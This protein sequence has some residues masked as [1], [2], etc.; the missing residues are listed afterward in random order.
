MEPRSGV[1]ETERSRSFIASEAW[2]DASTP[3]MTTNRSASTTS[4]ARAMRMPSRNRR[5][6]ASTVAPVPFPGVLAIYGVLPARCRVRCSVG[7]CGWSV[8]GVS[9]QFPLAENSGAGI[10]PPLRLSDSPATPSCAGPSAVVAELFPVAS[11]PDGAGRSAK[12]PAPMGASTASDGSASAAEEA[13]S[14]A[15]AAC[16]SEGLS[17]AATWPLGLSSASA[18]VAVPVTAPLDRSIEAT[19]PGLTMPS[20]VASAA[21]FCGASRCSTCW[22][23]SSLD[24]LRSNCSFLSETSSYWRLDTVMLVTR[25]A[26]RAATRTAM[27]SPA[28]PR[29]DLRMGAGTRAN[30][31]RRRGEA[32]WPASPSGCPAGRMT[33]CQGAACPIC[34]AVLSR[35]WTGCCMASRCCVAVMLCSL[36]L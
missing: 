26:I 34:G 33:G 35:V 5:P 11:S 3:W 9:G 19:S 6:L 29:P 1:I 31:V 17:G 25:T 2:P 30:G 8:R 20:F 7:Y 32:I 24:W 4:R 18:A 14:A 13:E 12:A 36:M 27:Q 21:R 10:V 15:A 22:R 28:N 16:F 23:S